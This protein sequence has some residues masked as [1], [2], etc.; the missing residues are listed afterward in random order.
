[1]DHSTVKRLAI[2][3]GFQSDSAVFL[4]MLHSFAEKVIENF[5]AETGQYVTND[6]SREAAMEQ[7]R[8]EERQKLQAELELARSQAATAE[9]WRGLATAKFGD[10]RTVQ[11]I[12]R[13]AAEEER[14]ACARLCEKPR[15][16]PIAMTEW[17]QGYDSASRNIA[18]AIRARGQK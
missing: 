11:E 15:T 3:S 7:A 18:A 8:A 9:K 6:E 2:Q 16:T 1:M 12:Q 13:E 5:L 10:G 4:P 17:C 14:E